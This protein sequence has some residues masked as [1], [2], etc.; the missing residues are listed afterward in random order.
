[1]RQLLKMIG[2]DARRYFAIPPDL[3]TLDKTTI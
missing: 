2:N 1:M 3:A